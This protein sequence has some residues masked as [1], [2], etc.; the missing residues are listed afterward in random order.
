MRYKALVVRESNEVAPRSAAA[1]EETEAVRNARYVQTVEECDSV[2]LPAGE[3]LVR[4]RYSSLNYKDAL[5]ANGNRGVTRSYPH[6]PGI[7]AAGVVAESTSKDFREGD[8]VIVTG[9]DL[10]MN[11][12]GGFGE[13]I[14]VPAAWAL[15]LPTSM[16]LRDSMSYGTAGL[17]AAIAVQR[18]V[19]A[20]VDS[21][22]GRVLVTGAKGGVGGFAVAI[23]SRIGFQVEAATGTKSA[24]D[25]LKGLGAL[26]IVSRD[27]LERDETKPLLHADWSG[28]VD[29]VGGKILATVIR[30][31]GYGGAVAACGNV[32]SGSFDGTVY[33][34]ILRG[35]SL[36]GVDSVSYPMAMRRQLWERLAGD[37]NVLDLKL[38]VE[39]CGLSLL[40]DRISRM[41]QGS[42]FGRV[43]VDLSK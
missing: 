29:T 9:F 43:L 7:D 15:H 22:S 1:G 40:S 13:Y 5:S 37:W 16:S 31:V 28:A 17:T 38:S 14:R 6:T 41:M 21:K 2:N 24:E 26:K 27:R 39:E 10:G 42:L 12:P 18:L 4:V 19:S 34:F 23:L 11:T 35:V 32:A 25:Y 30:S 33:P 8:E 3:L 36:L 20:G